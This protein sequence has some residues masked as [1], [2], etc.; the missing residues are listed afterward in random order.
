M[1]KNDLVRAV[2]AASGLS[3]ADAA[4]VVD[5]LTA[6]IAEALKSGKDVR[7][8]GFG[9]FSITE[10]PAREGRNPRTGEMLRLPEARR[11][12]FKAGSRLRAALDGDPTSDP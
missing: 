12:R 2:A 9:T 8:A 5:S 11:P 4:R 3:T 10:R 7:L 6:V 1:N